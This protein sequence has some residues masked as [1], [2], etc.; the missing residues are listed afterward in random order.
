[1]GDTEFAFGG[2]EEVVS[3]FGAEGDG[4]G[5]GVGVADVFAGEADEA[6]DDVEGW[7]AGLEHA[8]EVVE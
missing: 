8:G 1:M 7:F 4:E 6:A 5:G 3:V 2:A